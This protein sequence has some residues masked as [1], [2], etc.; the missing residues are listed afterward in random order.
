MIHVVGART[1]EVE[2]AACWNLLPARLPHLTRSLYTLVPGWW[3]VGSSAVLGHGVN[4]QYSEAWC[5][6]TVWRLQTGLG[7][8]KYLLSNL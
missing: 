8:C 4:S 3:W 6:D 7:S 5:V 1:A 2:Q